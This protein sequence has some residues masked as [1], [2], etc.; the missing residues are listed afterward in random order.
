[1]WPRNDHNGHEIHELNKAHDMNGDH[2]AVVHQ[3]LVEQGE[4]PVAAR[5]MRDE[6]DDERH[7]GLVPHQEA[8]PH[9]AQHPV[10][11]PERKRPE[12][13]RPQ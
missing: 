10:D 1:M 4:V 9:G 7:L 8:L 11:A 12:K 3:G 6:H 5:N 13:K 2:H